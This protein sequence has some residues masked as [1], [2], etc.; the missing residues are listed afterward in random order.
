MSRRVT[1]SADAK[2]DLVDHFTFI[3]QDSPNAA[4]RFLLAADEA[5]H[6]LAEMPRMG[7]LREFRNPDLK[8]LRSWP[9]PHFENYLIFY[10]PSDRDIDIVRVLHGAR[11][12]GAIFED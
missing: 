4:D 7:R 8:G 9:I 6:T 12:L 1:K 11:D 2:R 5:F 3:G 10:M